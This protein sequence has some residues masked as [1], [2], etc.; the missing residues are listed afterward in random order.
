MN[1]LSDNEIIGALISISG[2]K[3]AG[4][5]MNGIQLWNWSGTTWQGFD[6]LVD[7]ALCFQLMVKYDCDLIS[8]YRP[9]NDTHWECQIFT[10]NC[11]DAVSIY[12]DSPNKAICLA[13]I[14]ALLE[15]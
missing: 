4:M 9:N 3:S 1:D 8:P 14:E 13:I 5:L 6:A 15:Q 7:D 12:N 10:D 11:A 2:A